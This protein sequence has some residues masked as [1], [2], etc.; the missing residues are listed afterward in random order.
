MWPF[1]TSPSFDPAADLP[2]LSG[3]VI[4]VTGAS[5]G[6][7]LATTA[8]LLRANACVYLA[9]RSEAKASA[10][11]AQLH[12]EGLGMTHRPSGARLPAENSM[13]GYGMGEV[14]YLEL[15]LSDPRNAKK[16]AQEFMAQEERLDVLINNAAMPKGPY[17]KSHDGIQDTMMINHISPFVFTMS[18][19]PLL[20][21]T[22]R[23]DDSDVRI[24]NVSSGGIRLLRSGVRFRDM[25]DFNDEHTDSWDPG[26]ARYLRSK[27]ANALFTIELQRRLDAVHIPIVVMVVDPGMVATDGV[28]N[29]RYTLPF[30]LSPLFSFLVHTFWTAPSV[31]AHASVF[32]A[33]SCLVHEHVQEHKGAWIGPGGRLGKAPNRDAGSAGPARE[34]WDTTMEALPVTGVAVP[35]IL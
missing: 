14:H 6:I 1:T 26:F 30:P 12:S 24:V 19:L 13:A 33:T 10:A 35:E 16:A 34:L 18:L 22:A 27:L 11:I 3:K 20:V 2:D 15:D 32:A 31:G 4:I 5:S 17:L 28:L 29:V 9:A 7:G 21:R 8:H 25:N 23:E